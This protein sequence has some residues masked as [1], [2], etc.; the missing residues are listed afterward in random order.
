MA[1]P[2]PGT[3]FGRWTVVGLA[4]SASRYTEQYRRVR[5]RVRCACG[6]LRIVF[7]SDLQSGK[8]AGCKGKRCQLR[9]QAVDLVREVAG[10]GVLTE[11]I[12]ERLSSEGGDG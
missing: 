9:W 3:R 12:V 7:L 2:K 5:V 8:S 1:A 10:E 4:P 11:V 6:A